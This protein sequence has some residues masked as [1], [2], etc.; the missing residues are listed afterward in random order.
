[1][2]EW[3]YNWLPLTQIKRLS[4]EKVKKRHACYYTEDKTMSGF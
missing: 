3:L 1:M 4:I 2:F